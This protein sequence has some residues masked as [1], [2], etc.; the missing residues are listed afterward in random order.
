M[1][2]NDLVKERLKW[3]RKTEGLTQDEFANL[4]DIPVGTCRNVEQ[5][6]TVSFAQLHK[7]FQQPR[8]ARYLIWF[9]QGNS[10][11]S[12]GQ[13]SPDI[14]QDIKQQLKKSNPDFNKYQ[15]VTD[16]EVKQQLDNYQSHQP[17]DFGIAQKVL[18]DI[19]NAAKE[20]L[21]RHGIP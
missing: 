8:F 5:N 10:Y 11:P 14:L 13:I 20:S 15:E 19:T 16:E 7:I 2:S 9:F 3:M 18:E 6:G 12:I 17:A 1:T 4:V 21:N